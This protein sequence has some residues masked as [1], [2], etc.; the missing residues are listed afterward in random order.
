MDFDFSEEQQELRAAFRDY[1]RAEMPTTLARELWDHPDGVTAEGWSSLARLGWC[2]LTVPEA[3]GG[4]G[5][6][7]LELVLACEAMG[8]TVAPGPFWSTMALG[9]EL[10]RRLGSDE[11]Q[12]GLLS[13]VAAGSAR[14]TAAVAETAGRWQ[15]ADV[16]MVARRDGQGLQLDGEKL[17]VPDAR[18]ATNLLVAARL[19]DGIGV[20]VVPREAPGVTVEPMQTVDGS[21]KFDVVRF[22][23]VGVGGAALLGGAAV[24]G[25]VFDAAL[26]AARLALAAELAGIAEAA[27]A[28]TVE[29]LG[30]REQ[31][32]RPL[33]TF[34]ALQ[35]RCADMKVEVEN[36]K[37]LVYYA[38]WAL[39][40]GSDDARQAVAMAK[41]YASEA[42]PMVVADAVQLHGGIG[43]TW[44]HDLHMYFKRA[45]ADEVLLG[46]AVESR[47]FV[48]RTLG[49][50]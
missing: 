21:R 3:A 35:H 25:E 39:D 47:E 19:D 38:A 42:C 31:F 8:T 29:Y 45:K 17:F 2:G 50:A 48:A 9:V 32:G 6:G 13:A 14:L 37:S 46:D 18:S 43:F 11:Q 16:A 5:L 27:L 20:L 44:E 40:C 34:Q 33:A 4:S 7:M 22:D 28:L 23:G 49:L 41:A 1:V 36:T 12:E 26:D 30:V 10:V 24:A 15:A